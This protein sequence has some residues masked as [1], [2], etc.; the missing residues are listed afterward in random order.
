VPRGE[1]GEFGGSTGKIL[2]LAAINKER[3]QKSVEKS[4][5]ERRRKRRRANK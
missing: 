5:A 2:M 1:K 3:A 4:K